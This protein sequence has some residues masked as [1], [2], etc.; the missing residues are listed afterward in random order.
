[1]ELGESLKK[2]VYGFIIVSTTGYGPVA[3]P[4]I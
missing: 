4:I 2:V 1:M 3:V